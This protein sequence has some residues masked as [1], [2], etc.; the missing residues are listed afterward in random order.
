VTIWLPAT[1]LVA[2]TAAAVS[3]AWWLQSRNQ[4]DAEADFRRLVQVDSAEISARFRKH[5]DGLN[6]ARG[7]YATHTTVQRDMFRRYVESRNLPVEF[8]GV[9]AFGFIERV[10]RT[11]LEP[12]IATER[13]DGAPQFAVRQ[14]ERKDEADLYVIKFLE[15]AAA[16]AGTLGLDLGSE[17]VRRQGLLLALETG[18]PTVTGVITLVQDQRQ[19]PGVLLYVPVFRAVAGGAVPAGPGAELRGLLY[20]PIMLDELLDGLHTAAADQ[21]RVEL[22]DT[23]S[24]TVQGTPMYDTHPSPPERQ[25]AGNVPPA[26]FE[27]IHRIDLPGRAVT[28]RARST[29]AFEAAHPY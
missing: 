22:F 25:A 14:L 3:S 5:V 19:R 2:G 7:V 24:G 28:L 18:E 21:L 9:R 23:A 20:A 4:A 12:F 10:P 27:L 26:R 8:P 6:G 16:D 29:P 17:T 11:G 13:A 15:P 1:V